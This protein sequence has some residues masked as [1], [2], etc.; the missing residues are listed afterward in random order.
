MITIKF[1]FAAYCGPCEEDTCPAGLD[2][3]RFYLVDQNT[4]ICLGTRSKEL[5]WNSKGN[6]LYYATYQDGERYRWPI[7]YGSCKTWT[8]IW[9]KDV[10]M[11]QALWNYLSALN[12]LKSDIYFHGHQQPTSMSLDTTYM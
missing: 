10:K 11:V 7:L 4:C 6:I 12:A 9:N 8:G 1:H 2:K 3:T 5:Y